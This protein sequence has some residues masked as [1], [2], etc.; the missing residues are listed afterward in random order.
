MAFF[1]YEALVS[2]GVRQSGRIEA[3]HRD[4]AIRKLAEDG[5][6]IIKMKEVKLSFWTKDIEFGKKRVKQADFVAFCRQFAT[7]VRSG[8]PL[9]ESLQVLT[10]QT[11]SKHLKQALL[12]VTDS[13]IEGTALSDSFSAHPTIFPQMFVQM[14]YAGEISG[15]LDEV[16]D[17]TATY[18]EKQHETAEKIKSAMVYPASVG[19]MAVLVS[20]FLL[21]RVIPTFVTAFQSQHL[22]LPLPTR[23][24]LGISFFFTHRWYIAII[25]LAVL[26]AAGFWGYQYPEVRNRKDRYIL[27]IP[28][29]GGLL[30]KNAMARLARTLSI[31]FRSAVP[32]LQA[33]TI[34]ADVVGNRYLASTLLEARERLRSGESIVDPLRESEAFPPLFTQ[35]V[36]IGEQ[37]GNLDEML[38]KIANFYEADVATMVDRLR[39]LIEPV[40]IAFLAVVVGGIVLSALLPMFS[41]YQG[42]DSVS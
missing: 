9:V 36:R 23:I 28:I 37:T 32:A 35:M 20:I 24:V 30:Q 42:I 18:T 19:I 34:T 25:V 6:H 3:E 15:T 13:V 40:M 16:L 27:R 17:D 8:I 5:L 31:L 1:T 26:V 14:I 38:A 10:E 33:L 41:L 4:E 11:R 29:F 7:L 21:I 22:T 39:Q 2:R 12:D